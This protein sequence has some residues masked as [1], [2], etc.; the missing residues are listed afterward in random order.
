MAKKAAK[1][2]K[3][4]TSAGGGSLKG[5]GSSAGAAATSGSSGSAT[6]EIDRSRAA[7]A[8]YDYIERN[9]AGDNLK[10]VALAQ[11][12]IGEEG[13]AGTGTTN[14]IRGVMAQRPIQKGDAIIDIP[15]ELALNL[16][17]ESSDPTLPAVNLLQEYCRWIS[18]KG[19]G[20]QADDN[21]S[22]ARRKRND[23]PYFEMLPKYMG[24]DC[25]GSTDF[26]SDEA[27]DALQCPPIKDETLRRRETTMA[28]FER[29]VEP[30]AQISSNMYRWDDG[31]TPIEASHLQWA[32]WLIT[33]R[34]LT[35]QGEEGTGV[36][37]RLMIP[38]I[39]MCN[40]DR[41]SPHVLTGRA[42]KG[43]RLKILA[44]RNVAAG[45]QINICYGGGVAGND[46]FIQD[47]G[48]L[49]TFDDGTAFDLVAKTLEGIQEFGS[50]SS[51]L[52]MSNSDKAA[53]LEALGSTSITD[54]EKEL[55]KARER[56]VRAAIEFRIGVKKALER[57]AR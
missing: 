51:A 30:M 55:A 36:S 53:A 45:E 11:F 47:Y 33:S 42:V 4:K 17:R 46:R 56:D 10:R 26:F 44:G 8:F 25:L 41:D 14:S 20:D 16:G 5:F 19:D 57:L 40:H 13:D 43:G 34:V 52:S 35:V 31:T 9:G 28:R 50:R 29:D 2:K 37:Y 49:D 48:F 1:K 38:L 3:K 7:L 22:A 23:G 39:D 6:V 54:D 18:G 27:L 32:V 21:G 24:E 15:Y 12:P